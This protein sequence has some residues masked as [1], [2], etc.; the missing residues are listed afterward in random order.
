MDRIQVHLEMV[1]QILDAVTGRP[2]EESGAGGEISIINGKSPVYKG[3]G[4]YLFFQPPESETVLTFRAH[5]YREFRGKPA[6]F[7]AT[8]GI[9]R[10]YIQPDSQYPLST[11]I[12]GLQGR[13]EPETTLILVCREPGWQV[14]LTEDYEAGA[15]RISL[16][17]KGKEGDTG[18]EFRILEQEQAELLKIT[19]KGNIGTGQ[20]GLESPL[21]HSYHKD[22]AVL[23]PIKR[24]PVDASGEFVCYWMRKKGSK[25][26]FR[27]EIGQPDGEQWK[28]LELYAGTRLS[29]GR[30]G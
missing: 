4:Y 26:V 15:G 13:A 23:L 17:F 29:A 18:I 1:L 2:L 14:Y 21:T 27:C 19:G 28:E 30:I 25:S 16:L 12:F 11:E 22:K 8:D 6:D 3:E 9:H 24:I 7:V 10:I 20:Y 5:G